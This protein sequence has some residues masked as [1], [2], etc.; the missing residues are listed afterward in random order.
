MTLYLGQ[1]T[2][3]FRNPATKTIDILPC[4]KGQGFLLLVLLRNA[5]R[6]ATALT[7]SSCLS[8]AEVPVSPVVPPF[9]AVP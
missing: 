7:N 9:G 8:S 5:M 1:M 3:Y 4:P 6:T 2:A